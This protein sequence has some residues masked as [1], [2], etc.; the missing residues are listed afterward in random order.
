M[1]VWWK[2]GEQGGTWH[3]PECRQGPMEEQLT[4]PGCQG[5]KLAQGRWHTLGL[6]LRG[7]TEFTLKGL[8]LGEGQQGAEQAG[9]AWKHIIT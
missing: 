8:G 2:S 1:T 4:L 7:W 5:T 9:R 3:V 6:C